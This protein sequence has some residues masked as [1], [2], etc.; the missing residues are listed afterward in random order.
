MILFSKLR[1][2]I[3]KFRRKE[4]ITE[5]ASLQFMNSKSKNSKFQTTTNH[6]KITMIYLLKHNASQI[7]K[8]KIKKREI[9]QIW[10]I[11]DLGMWKMHYLNLNI[12]GVEFEKC[13][14]LK[15]KGVKIVR[16][17]GIGWNRNI[18]MSS[19]ILFLLT[20]LKWKRAERKVL[21]RIL[22]QKCLDFNIRSKFKTL[23]SEYF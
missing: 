17:F 15:F 16:K 19:S 23:K 18:V 13:T 4:I 9:Y 2:T 14:K 7:Y 12:V 8:N 11:D 22:K 10:E 5:E 6:D 1:V 21:A 20:L 3:Y